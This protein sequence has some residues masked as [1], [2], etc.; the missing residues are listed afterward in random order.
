MTITNVVTMVDG[1]FNTTQVDS[2]LFFNTQPSLN[3]LAV[4]CRTAGASDD[5]NVVLLVPGVS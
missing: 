1:G 3:G 5:V 4:R 2:S